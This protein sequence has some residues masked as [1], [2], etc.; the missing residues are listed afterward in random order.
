MQ[1][2]KHELSSDKPLI[3]SWLH[4]RP[5]STAKVY[6]S[7]AMRL[8]RAL[9]AHLQQTTAS[10]VQGWASELEGSTNTRR[11]RINAAKSLLRYAH[12]TG[13]TET[14]LSRFLR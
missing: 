13:H 3:E 11:L 14:D 10:D 2:V 6:R 5:P 4:G 9:P 8:L 7:T 1:R 12:E